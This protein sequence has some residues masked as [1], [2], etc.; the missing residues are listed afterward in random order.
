M[1]PFSANES[2]R[3]SIITWV[4]ILICI[5]NLKLACI[6]CGS[7]IVFRSVDFSRAS[8]TW[9]LVGFQIG[10]IGY[11]YPVT[12]K[13][14]FPGEHIPYHVRSHCWLPCCQHGC[15]HGVVASHLTSMR[16]DV[17]S[18]PAQGKFSFKHLFSLKIW[19]FGVYR[20][21]GSLIFSIIN[22]KVACIPS[23]SSIVFC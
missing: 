22:L 1:T 9:S 13:E 8:L 16:R 2:A 10:V 21:R 6:P 14:N 5:I 20:V 4:I 19:L 18:N 11:P 23:G 3:I 17:G 7:S 15:P 12:L